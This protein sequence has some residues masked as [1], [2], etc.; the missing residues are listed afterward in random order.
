MSD[1]LSRDVMSQAGVEKMHLA[2]RDS[3]QAATDESIT[4]SAMMTLQLR[5]MLRA[6]EGPKRTLAVR[7]TPCGMSG[8]R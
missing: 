7:V 3:I 4:P 8:G 1:L 2:A 6:R 5:Q